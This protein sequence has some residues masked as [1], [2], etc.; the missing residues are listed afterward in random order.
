[1]RENAIKI[2]MG[3][4]ARPMRRFAR[5]SVQKK[6]VEAPTCPEGNEWYFE[7]KREPPQW[8]SVFT[9]GRGRGIVRLITW[10]VTPAIDMATSIAKKMRIHFLLS[11]IHAIPK[12][13]KPRATCK[14]Q[15]PNRL[16]YRMKLRIAWLWCCAMNSRTLLSKWNESATAVAAIAIPINQ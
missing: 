15:S 16:T 11:R 2:G 4:Q 3:R 8:I 1:M 12:R 5:N 6:A 9:E 7:L 14:G 13:S 10:P